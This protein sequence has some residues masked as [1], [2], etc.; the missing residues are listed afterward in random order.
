MNKKLIG[1]LVPVLG[2]IAIVGSGFSAWHFG[3]ELKVEKTMNGNG[4]V[5]G[6]TSKGTL[7]L[8]TETVG[9]TLDQ[10]AVVGAGNYETVGIIID[11]ANK[12]NFN[13][14]FTG[15]LNF[16]L[17]NEANN[18]GYTGYKATAKIEGGIASYV[19]VSIEDVTNMTNGA[20][21]LMKDDK[22]AAVEAKGNLVLSW[23]AGHK[24]TTYDDYIT[25]LNTLQGTGEG[26]TAFN[27]ETAVNGLDS[28]TFTITVSVTPVK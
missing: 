2:G 19:D 14:T 15:D 11:D 20:I 28:F 21:A 5:T 7:T 12:D 22:T 9:V 26:V 1:L 17:D 27:S 8:G 23:K 3:E 24:P 6:L 25:M 16:A 4:T 10:K 13:F 18:W